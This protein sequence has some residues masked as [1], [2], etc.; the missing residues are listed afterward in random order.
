MMAICARSSLSMFTPSGM[1]SGNITLAMNSRLISGTPRISSTYSTQSILHRRQLGRAAAEGDQ[2]RQ[3]EGEGQAEG[4]QDQRDR[5]PA[6]ASPAARSGRPS[7]PPHISTPITASV[8]DPDQRQLLAPEAAH[9]GD[10]IEPDEQHDA[11]RRPPLLLVRIAA[12]QDQPV[13]VG[14]RP[15][16]RR[17]RRAPPGRR[18]CRLAA[19]VVRHATRRR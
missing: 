4:R 11:D 2:D 13:L 5:Q 7:T 1:N 15:P 19:G 3:R 6:P 9:G 10:D 18:R 16:S 8:T 12:E 17:R 14:D